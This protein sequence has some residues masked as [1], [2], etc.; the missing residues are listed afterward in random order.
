MLSSSWLS[1]NKQIR[2]NAMRWPFGLLFKQSHELVQSAG[3]YSKNDRKLI[4]LK[5]GNWG[6]R[7]YE[8]YWAANVVA[9]GGKRIIDLGMGTP[10][11]HT[12]YN[13]VLHE[14]KPDYYAGIDMDERMKEE[15]QEG[16]NFNL[17]WM[18]MTALDFE[19]RSFDIAYCISVMEHL[20]VEDLRKSC[21]ELYR[22]LADDGKIAITLDEVWN[23][24]GRDWDWN[25]LEKDLI[26][27]KMY[28]RKDA[29]FN[30]TDFLSLISHYFIPCEPVT[31]KR[32]NKD[33]KILHNVYW[34]SCVSY[35]LLRKRLP[36]MQVGK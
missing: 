22:V 18:N 33:G 8:Y 32:N 29:S 28:A 1:D 14:L 36:G 24:D 35:V 2:N 23:I 12:W 6:S 11:T 16:N 25:V 27:R 30:M 3:Y 21:A 5:Y 7:P 34:N 13:Y 31:C 15:A 20:T 4:G 17:R 19:D 10:S 26:C 9:A